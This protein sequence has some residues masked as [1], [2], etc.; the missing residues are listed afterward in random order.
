MEHKNIFASDEQRHKNAD[1]WQNK[2]NLVDWDADWDK[3]CKF[4]E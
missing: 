1:I 2:K 4:L 3:L